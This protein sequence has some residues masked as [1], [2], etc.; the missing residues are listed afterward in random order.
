MRA[1]GS[2]M[3]AREAKKDGLKCGE[4]TVVVLRGCESENLLVGTRPLYSVLDPGPGN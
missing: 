2:C 4:T 1:I 3:L